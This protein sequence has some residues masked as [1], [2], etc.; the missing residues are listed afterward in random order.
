MRSLMTQTIAVTEAIQSLNQAHQTFGL[1]RDRDRQWFPEWW[2]DRREISDSEKQI[3]D[4]LKDGEDYI[5]IKLNVRDRKYALSQKFT[6]S[7]PT[8]NELYSVF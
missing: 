8:Q 4:T 3:L 5:F 2:Q 7:N 1:K 6:L